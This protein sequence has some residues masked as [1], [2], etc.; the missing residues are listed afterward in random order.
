MGEFPTGV[1]IV[2]T[3]AN[4]RPHGMTVNSLT[5]VSLEPP[6]VLVCF[7]RDSRTAEAVTSS[8]RFAV[9]LLNNRQS[10]LANHF[11]R[12]G[13]DHFEGLDFQVGPHGVPIIPGSLS[14][15]VCTVDAVHSGGDH[16][17]VVGEVETYAVRGGS[18]LTFFRGRYHDVV[19]PGRPARHD[20]YA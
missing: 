6:L 19:G 13:A 8:G 17:I 12:R 10:A 1:A 9:N 14:Y 2:T 20:W 16:Q 4:G 7:T 5:S 18:P 11:A 3:R 15:L